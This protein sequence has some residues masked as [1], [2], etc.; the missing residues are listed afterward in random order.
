M[1]AGYLQLTLSGGS[2]AKG[3]LLQSTRDE[4]SVNFHARKNKTFLE[5]KDK[6]ESRIMKHSK[7]TD[8]I[9]EADELEKLASLKDKGI[10]TPDEF[11]A[12]KK[13]IL[14]L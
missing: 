6:I 12:K 2:E 11:E 4:N 7:G 10:I 5:A 13:K 14:D 1:T 3:G 8:T 9:S